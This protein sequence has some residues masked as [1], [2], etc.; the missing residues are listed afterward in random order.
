VYKVG[1]TPKYIPVNIPDSKI[2]DL[3]IYY[4]QM[5]Q[6]LDT[7]IHTYVHT[8]GGSVSVSGRKWDVELQKMKYVGQNSSCINF[9]QEK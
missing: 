1:I 4:L 3:F 8:F 5:A 7:Y 6:T 9:L 2:A